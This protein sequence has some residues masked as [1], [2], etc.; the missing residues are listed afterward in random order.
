M[1]A[2]A[3]PTKSLAQ[4]K[5][6]LARQVHIQKEAAQAAANLKRQIRNQSPSVRMAAAQAIGEAII[7]AYATGLRHFDAE[8]IRSEAIDLLPKRRKADARDLLATLL[9]APTSDR[10]T[11]NE[12][13]EGS[14]ADAPTPEAVSGLTPTN[15]SSGSG[16][17]SPDADKL[18]EPTNYVSRSLRAPVRPGTFVKRS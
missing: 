1:H 4:L 7:A 14:R 15:A 2:E 11:S 6:E 16:E 18:P 17:F 8:Q 5:R 3:T 12:L 9:A 13:Y 10:K